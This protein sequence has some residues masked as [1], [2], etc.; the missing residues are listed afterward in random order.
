MFFFYLDYEENQILRGMI[1]HSMCIIR[2][3]MLDD[4]DDTDDTDDD[5]DDDDGGGIKIENFWVNSASWENLSIGTVTPILPLDP[6]H[7]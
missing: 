2:C 4:T 6:L 1:P 3:A 5:D 7:Q